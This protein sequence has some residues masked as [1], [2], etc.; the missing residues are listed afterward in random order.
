MLPVFIKP[1]V[2]GA[3][4]NWDVLESKVTQLVPSLEPSNEKPIGEFVPF[5]AGLK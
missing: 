4:W 1:L 2:N 3:V 5:D